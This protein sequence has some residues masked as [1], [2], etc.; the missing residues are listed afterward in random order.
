MTASEHRESASAGFA[1]SE[2]E[3]SSPRSLQTLGSSPTLPFWAFGCTRTPQAPSPQKAWKGLRRSK[4][5]AKRPNPASLLLPR[6]F[7]A[8]S[9]LLRG[10][11][12]CIGHCMQSAV[13]SCG[14]NGEEARLK[15]DRVW[16]CEY[17]CEYE[18]ECEFRC[19][20]VCSA[21]SVLLKWLP[22]SD[23]GGRCLQFY[24]VYR[25][26]E[27]LAF[28]PAVGPQEHSFLDASVKAGEVYSYQVSAWHDLPEA[29]TPP[30]AEGDEA[31]SPSREEGDSRCSTR[32]SSWGGSQRSRRSLEGL[33][34]EKVKVVPGK[35]LE[36]PRL[37]DR[38]PHILLQG[39]NW[40][41]SKNPLGWYKV[42][43]SKLPDVKRLGVSILWCPPPTECVG[44]EGYMPTRW[45][46]L[47]SHYGTRREL[48][49][50]IKQSA[51]LGISCCVD[52]VA[53]HRCGTKQDKNGDWTF[54]EQPEWGPW[55]VVKNNLQVREKRSCF[56][57]RRAAALRRPRRG[58]LF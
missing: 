13:S 37:G 33:L 11:P 16:G 36:C 56:K 23:E 6:D 3:S 9:E 17:E 51:S 10:S 32:A 46:S 55:A 25:N 49:T 45:Y 34:S 26:G 15:K 41:S 38:K 39:F 58:F 48:E 19:V 4:F 40:N 42:L 12:F 5:V 30:W 21:F 31:R 22:P 14:F 54:F 35:A 27:P 8:R 7:C 28:V 53:N 47:D 24:R 18:Y 50:L 43:V 29:E 20:S 52:L 57:R 1:L 44:W 2:T